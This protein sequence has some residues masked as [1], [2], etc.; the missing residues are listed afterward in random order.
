[1]FIITSG[2]VVVL[3][4]WPDDKKKEFLPN[5]YRRDAEEGNQGLQCVC[6]DVLYCDVPTEPN[7]SQLKLVHVTPVKK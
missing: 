6:P 3:T 7:L 5:I 1:M 4:F 2:A